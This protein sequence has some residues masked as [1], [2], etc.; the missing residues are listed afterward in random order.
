MGRDGHGAT[1]PSLMWPLARVRWHRGE[2]PSVPSIHTAR[3]KQRGKLAL[4]PLSMDAH[5]II[6]AGAGAAADLPNMPSRPPTAPGLA[7]PRLPAPL[8]P[9]PNSSIDSRSNCPKG[10]AVSGNRRVF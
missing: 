1:L 5:P 6:A 7:E 8:C 9:G 4:L 2:P 10:S 3:S